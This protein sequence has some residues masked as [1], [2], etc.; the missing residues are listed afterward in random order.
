M[1][2]WFNFFI[3]FQIVIFLV[4][5]TTAERKTDKQLIGRSISQ[6]E[7]AS[8]I[9]SNQNK[10]IYWELK[11][12][13]EDPRSADKAIIFNDRAVSIK[14][15]CDSIRDS[16]SRF[17]TNPEQNIKGLNIFYK[18]AINKLKLIDSES[19]GIFQKEF[20]TAFALPDSLNI[21]TAEQRK[22]AIAELRCSI[23][24]LENQ[25]IIFIRSHFTTESV[26][27]D[28]FG[29]LI[30]QNTTHLKKGENLIIT[31]GI[32]A[33]S[34]GAKPEIKIDGRNAPLTDGQAVS[35]IKID[36]SPGKH[37]KAVQIDF[38]DETGKTRSVKEK[39]EYTV[40]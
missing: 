22:M 8:S 3:N 16:L 25:I 27:M 13:A 35:K 17:D 32:G 6:F 37:F 10:M 33:Y 9:I 40:D 31:A 14:S 38:T 29:P 23:T 18:T 24:M 12:R 19:A 4:S 30:G 7:T 1:K 21:T 2:T 5:C 20:R 15:F 28:A 36:D 11:E 34:T 26:R 39:I